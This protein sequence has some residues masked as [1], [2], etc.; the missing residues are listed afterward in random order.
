[1][2]QSF[3]GPLTGTNSLQLNS[4]ASQAHPILEQADA[5]DIVIPDFTD[6]PPTDEPLRPVN[7]EHQTRHVAE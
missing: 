6:D 7:P 4:D 1:M 5:V 3:P 2:G